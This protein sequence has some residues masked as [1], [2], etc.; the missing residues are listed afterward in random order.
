MHTDLLII[1]FIINFLSVQPIVSEAWWVFREHGVKFSKIEKKRILLV[2][3]TQQQLY[4]GIFHSFA[5]FRICEKI[6][7]RRR[8]R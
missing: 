8:R 7:R 6:C 2:K 5:G 1:G 3:E 4:D